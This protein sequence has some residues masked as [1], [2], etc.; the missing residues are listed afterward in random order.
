MT[1]MEQKKAAKKFV[2]NWS[3]HGYEKGESQKFWIDLLTSVFACLTR[4]ELI[5]QKR[6]IFFLL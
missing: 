2:K 4:Q 1:Q 5:L 6:K 3:G